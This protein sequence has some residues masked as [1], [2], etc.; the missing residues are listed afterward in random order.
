MLGSGVI[1]QPVILNQVQDDTWLKSTSSPE[2]PFTGRESVARPEN[3]RVIMVRFQI[4]E[5]ARAP[6]RASVANI[7][8]AEARPACPV[9]KNQTTSPFPKRA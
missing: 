2:R 8:A 6:V 1:P 9:Q 7:T 3:R 5:G 4:S